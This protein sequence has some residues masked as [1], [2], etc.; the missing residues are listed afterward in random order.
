MEPSNSVS[1]DIQT[2]PSFE[3]Y[4]HT[5]IRNAK[6]TTYQDKLTLAASI[7]ERVYKG[8]R[9]NVPSP[10]E[11]EDIIDLKDTMDEIYTQHIEI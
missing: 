3:N 4:L 5:F 6:T 2:L 1:Q 9:E 10:D 7:Y 8:D 11:L